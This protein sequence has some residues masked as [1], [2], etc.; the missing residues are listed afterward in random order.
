MNRSTAHE[1][2]LFSAGRIAE[3]IAR[4]DETV[5]Q[6]TAEQCAVI[7][8]PVAGSTLVI[9]GAGSGKTETMANRV[10]W[11]VANGLVDPENVLGLTFTRKAAGEL[12][13]RIATRLERFTE[14]LQHAAERGRLSAREAARAVDLARLLG[15]GLTLP[16]VGTYNAFA[17]GVLQEFGAAAGVA[18]AAVVID[19]ASAWRL[20]REVILASDDPDLVSSTLRTP[21]LVRHTIAIDHAVADNLASFARVEQVVTEFSRVIDLPYNEKDHIGGPEGKNYADIVR[22]VGNVAETPLLVRLAREF[23]AAKE[24]RG[25]VEFSD[26]LALATRTLDAASDAI[27]TLRQRHAAVLLDEVQDTS[28]G[29]T[30]LLSKIFA[31]RPVMAVG[32]PH[33]SIYGWRGASAEGLRSFHRDFGTGGR[34]G[35]ATTLTLSTSWRNPV[36][37]LEAANTVAAPLVAAST[38]EVPR[39]APRPGAPQGVVECV[40]P[41][42]VHEERELVAGWMARS[43][44]EY[45]R[46]HGELPTAAVIF[47]N[48]RHMARFSAALSAEGVPNRIVGLGGLLTTPE[49]TDVVSALRCVWY[50][51]AGGDLIRLLAGPRFRLGVAD[52]AGLRDAARWFAERDTGLQRLSEEDRAADRVLPDPDRRVT[53]IDALDV[54]TTI[55]D[56]SHRALATI[57]PM[58]LDRLRE[59]G[60]MLAELRQGVGGDVGDLIRATVNALRL[61]IE[62]EANESRG[63]GGGAAALANLE[64]FGEL[65]AQHLAVDDRGTLASMLEWIERAIES[66]EVDEHVP[67]PEPGTVQLITAH[68]SKGLEW[69]LVAVPRLV[70]GEFPAA[71]RNGVGWLRKGQLP[72]ELRGDAAARP[73]LDW[74][75]AS[76]QKELRDRIAAYVAESKERYAEEERRLGYVALTRSADRLL[77]SGSFWGGQ[78]R[79]R[80]PSVFLTDLEEQGLLPALPEGSGHDEDPGEAAELTVQWPLDPLGGRAE[81]VL[82]AAAAVQSRLSAADARE[83]SETEDPRVEID[84][85]VRL[86]IAEREAQRK[87]GRTGAGRPERLTASTFHEFIEDPAAAERARLRPVPQ[88]PF[89]RTRIGNRFH[90]WVER[91]STTSPGTEV[92]LFGYDP[93][94]WDPG[95]AEFDT[96]RE[97]APLIEE[98]ERSRWA[99]RQ[100]IAVELEVTLPFAG[101]TLVCKLDAVYRT[102]DAEGDRYEIVDWKAGRPPRNDT[103]QESRFFQLDLYRHAYALWAGLDPSKIDVSLF[104]VA[105]GIELRGTGSRSLEEL[106]A[107]WS[108]AADTL[109]GGAEN[110]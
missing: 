61:D 28:V 10:V 72:D 70:D 87:P 43:R 104:Y 81:Q 56:R 110:S 15:D 25:L 80:K 1:G 94:E 75:L 11:I 83:D 57:S 85:T 17:S 63:H 12:R 91:R 27:P 50:A 66:D 21:E 8:Q 103:E 16:E 6:P 18:S 31:G 51:D 32:D 19:E 5:L 62:L 14:G 30:R 108:R 93:E 53:L 41:E 90:E 95:R 78:T 39:L 55:R 97:L 82:A 36:A 84:E 71:P 106:E 102:N 92:P 101:R 65:V 98:F 58:G 73:R 9:A 20:A 59:A 3:I 79:P 69:D 64:T 2:A 52:I 42:S 13:D 4:P 7:E 74:R 45:R 35:L 24:R 67:P 46:E 76:D 33:Q 49:V 22:A 60:R 47:R 89:R 44:A 68:G 100:P 109:E 29:Q 77:L 23:S 34:R 107:I 96:E 86:L 48:R 37:V 99:H 105:E 26:Q 38:V 54:I 88:R 40:Y